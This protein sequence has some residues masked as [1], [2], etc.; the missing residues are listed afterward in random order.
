MIPTDLCFDRVCAA[1]LI[2]PSPDI[3][4]L[5]GDARLP[6]QWRLTPATEIVDYKG[7]YG[8]QVP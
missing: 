8:T 7:F 3:T 1:V 2:S 6:L 4:R 5:L